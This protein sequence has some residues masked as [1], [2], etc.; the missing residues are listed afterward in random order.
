MDTLHFYDGYLKPGSTTSDQALDGDLSID[1][2]HTN[3]S[4]ADG[5]RT[6]Y[7]GRLRDRYGTLTGNM[8]EDLIDTILELKPVMEK[9]KEMQETAEQRRRG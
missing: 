8:L 3:E 4:D 7:L 1:H 2:A 6:K 5:A 9:R